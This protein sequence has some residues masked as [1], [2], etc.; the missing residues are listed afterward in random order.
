MATVCLCVCPTKKSLRA[1]KKLPPP[2]A[3][4]CQRPVNIGPPW[5]T[6]EEKIFRFPPS[7][8]VNKVWGSGSRESGVGYLQLLRRGC[9]HY[10]PSGEGQ[11]CS[12]RI[13]LDLLVS[14]MR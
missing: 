11:K 4:T 13:F 8:G 14:M 5:S 12:N 2:M 3:T 1:V 6:S 7:K 10:A 9:V